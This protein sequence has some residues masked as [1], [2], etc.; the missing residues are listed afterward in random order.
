MS[1]ASTPDEPALEALLK[2]LQGQVQASKRDA[3]TAYE[4]LQSTV[5][6][7]EATNEELQ[8]TTEQL[9]TMNEELQ[10]T[11][12]Q[13][14]TINDELSQRTTEF[15]DASSFLEAILT[16]IEGGVV[17][18]RELRVTAWNHGAELLWGPGWEEAHGQHLMNLE[19]GLPTAELRVPIRQAMADGG[20]SSEVV[21]DAKN[22]LGE[23][24][25]CKVLCSPLHLNG[26]TQGAIL[27]MEDA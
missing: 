5:E 24:V 8:S 25:R 18:D 23:S 26:V 19:I 11:S 16:S 21:V 10:S 22:R 12:E 17:V 20:S 9:E 27:L 6:E 3:E 1:N 15:N 7:L 2:R 14:A 4:E 13:L